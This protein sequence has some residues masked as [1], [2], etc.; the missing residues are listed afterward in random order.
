[1]HFLYALPAQAKIFDD[2]FGQERNGVLE[3]DNILIE[4]NMT[5]PISVRH[6]TISL[7]SGSQ[8]HGSIHAPHLES[9]TLKGKGFSE[10]TDWLHPE[11]LSN[12]TSVTCKYCDNFSLSGWHSFHLKSL[13]FD[14]RVRTRFE[15]YLSGNITFGELKEQSELQLELGLNRLSYIQCQEIAQFQGHLITLENKT[16]DRVRDLQPVHFPANCLPYREEIDQWNSAA[17]KAFKQQDLETAHQIFRQSFLEYPV[18]SRFA[19]NLAIT[20]A[21]LDKH[22]DVI[23][24]AETVQKL[25]DVRSKDIADID[26]LAYQSAREMKDLQYAKYWLDLSLKAVNQ[27]DRRQQFSAMD[28]WVGEENRS[29]CAAQ[30]REFEY[31][32]QRFELLPIL[33]L[34][35]FKR[36]IDYVEFQEVSTIWKNNGSARQATIDPV[37][38]GFYAVAEDMFDPMYSIPFERNCEFGNRREVQLLNTDWFDPWSENENYYLHYAFSVRQAWAQPMD[39]SQCA[40]HAMNGSFVKR[41]VLMKMIP[42]Y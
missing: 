27:S 20:A 6:L 34:G 29:L 22:C 18:L 35:S 42:R 19:Y 4:K 15:P 14:H 33:E 39:I 17:V 37:E 41:L 25:A 30:R 9:L 28:N 36:L 21:H 3:C 10:V 26:Y 24:V 23:A 11:S 16:H 31:S 32:R 8:I 38:P 1:M 13:I 12:L 2:C 7:Q 40:D 5:V